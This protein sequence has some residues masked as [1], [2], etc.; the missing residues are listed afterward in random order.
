MLGSVQR[1]L[2][3][4]LSKKDALELAGRADNNRVVNFSGPPDIIGRFA[5]VKITQVVRHTLRGELVS[6]QI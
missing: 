2:V 5:E 6:S 3:E 4:G 1:V